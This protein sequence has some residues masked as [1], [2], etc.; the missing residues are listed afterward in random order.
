MTES[1]RKFKRHQSQ[2]FQNNHGKDN[3]PKKITSKQGGS[4]LVLEETQA[5]RPFH[6]CVL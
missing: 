3:K 6:S 1:P 5:I 2:M 4:V